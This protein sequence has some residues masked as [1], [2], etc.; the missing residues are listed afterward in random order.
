MKTW[1]YIFFLLGLV[2]CKQRNH[3]II[4]LKNSSSGN[5]YFLISK[6][7]TPVSDEIQKIRPISAS[8][9]SDLKV[10]SIENDSLKV[11]KKN[12]YRNLVER[13]SVGI[14]LSSESVGIFVN[15]VTIQ[16]I[17]EDRYNGSL[18]IFIIN[19]ADL[20]KNSNQE[21]VNKKLCK[22]FTTIVAEELKKDTLLVEYF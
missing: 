4:E 6:N 11:I 21:I 1:L 18:N 19:E 17:I 2:S 22:H 8:P 20:I 15:A 5:I 16:Q 13:D 14:L 10:M 9:I 3:Q 7:S 12:L